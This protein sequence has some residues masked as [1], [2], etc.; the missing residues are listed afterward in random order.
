VAWFGGPLVQRLL[1]PDVAWLDA[2]VS[3]RLLLITAI[4]AIAGGGIAAA[5]P[6]LQTSRRELAASVTASS[7]RT[8]RR[9]THTQTAMLI[10]QGAL[11]VLLLVGAGLFVRSLTA[12]QSLDLGMDVDRLL[13]VSLVGGDTPPSPDL[14]ERLDAGVQRI[15]G[16]ERTTRVAGTLPFISSWATRLALPGVAERPRVDDGGPYLHAVGPEYFD[17]VGTRIVEGR[18]FTTDDR[19]GAERV[20]VVNQTMARLFWPGK[21]AIGQC[22]QIGSDNP[23]CSTVIGI[24]TN[25]RRQE[26]IEGDSL[27]YY[28]PSAQAP[29][30]LRNGGQL[31]IRT[32]TA[33]P[34]EQARIAE[35]VRRQ[36]LQL[37]PSLR[38]VSARSLETIISPQLRSWRL[39]AALFGAFGVLALV[40]VTIG[41]YS[42][43]AF[44]VE[45][46]RRE[47]GIRAAFGASSSSLVGLVVRDGVKVTLI[48]IALGVALA[49][50]ASPLASDLLYRIE[51][52]DRGVFLTV[53]GILIAASIVASALPALRAGRVDPT[54]ALRAE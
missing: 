54:T 19:D 28:I 20:V 53:V 3:G 4:G 34:D 41:L 32:T 49:W 26:L 39:G 14:R 12:V 51:P 24:A 37:A 17:T 9:R 22:L 46:R 44:T 42:V 38:Y 21:S 15:P 36:A 16:V 43:L 40:V 11:S 35:A 13:V 6:M 47:M 45:G 8:S 2:A 23:P 5:L 7:A 27:L 25:T 48:G 50:W 1:F 18:G 29:E 30:G 31:V 52:R 10:V 33:D